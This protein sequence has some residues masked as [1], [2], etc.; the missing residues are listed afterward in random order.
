MSTP[1]T[2][3]VTGRR[4]SPATL[5][6]YHLGRA[7]RNK[8]LRY[9]ADPPRVEEIVAV[10]RT[11]GEGIHAERVRGVIV[12]LWRA[13]LRI[14]EALELFEADLDERRGAVLVRRGKGGRRRE[15]GMDDWGFE[16]LRPWL[17]HR[18][19]LPLGPLFCVID[20]PTRGRAWTAAGVRVKLRRLA[21]DAGVRRPSRRTAPRA[22][23]RDGARVRAAERDP[24]P[25]RAQQPRRHERLPAGDRQRRDRQRRP[26]PQ[27]AD[28]ARQ[29]RP[30][31]VERSQRDPDQDKSSV[32]S[33]SSFRGVQDASDAARRVESRHAPTCSGDNCSTAA[34]G[35]A[36]PRMLACRA[37]RV[38]VFAIASL[39]SPYGG[40]PR[41]K[42]VT[43]ALHQLAGDA[44]Q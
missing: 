10:M 3:D 11:A 2:L 36:A 42:S 40:M 38:H 8:G 26:R 32:S 39:C 28:D 19:E 17:S 6:G 29:R 20:G 5:P 43:I 24:A 44:R 13:G 16:Q 33:R 18:S 4:R 1:R 31:A 21:L 15:V 23:R 30:A 7:P 37:R 9:P 25:A 35:A 27:S 14:R 34:P 41:T 12:V 22:R